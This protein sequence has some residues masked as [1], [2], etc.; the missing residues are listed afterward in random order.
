[1]PKGLTFLPSLAL[2]A[3]MA[4]PVAAE[5]GPGA[6]TVVARVNGVEITLG[7]MIIAHATLPEQYQALPGDVLFNGILDQLIQ[8]SA[9]AQSFE[10]DVP[11]RIEL[12]LENEQRSLL[13]GEVLET[14][15]ADA[16]SDTD[17]QAAYD[18]EFATAEAGTEYN[19]AHILVETEAEAQAIVADL[20]G[21]ADF[22][23][24]A[25][26]K[27][28]GPSG[29]SGGALD[30]FGTGQMVPEFEA[31]VV[32]LEPGAV[33]DPVQTQFGWHVIT[34]N[35]TRP[36]SA[37]TLDEVRNQIIETLRT[38]AIDAHIDALTDAA[39]IDRPTIEGLD[40]AVL[41]DLTKLEN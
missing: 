19:A 40:P 14:V 31:A 2:V 26:A 3:A 10:G 6:D 22:G 11:A 17:I 24:T 5:T 32:A 9:L 23:E 21:G 8:Q 41:R 13:A 37:P 36:K 7:H 39:Q 12:S 29:P 4:L 20:R 27:S 34:V 33:S 35:E 25:K 38:E 16:V 30:W 1:M 15:M 18:A 28:T